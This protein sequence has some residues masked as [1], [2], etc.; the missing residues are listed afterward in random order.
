MNDKVK[1]LV[2]NAGMD[3]QS[4]IALDNMTKERMKNTGESYTE[5]ALHIAKYLIHKNT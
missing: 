3:E 4:A 2:E 5:A 1:E